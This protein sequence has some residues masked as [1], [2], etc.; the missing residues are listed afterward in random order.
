MKCMYAGWCVGVQMNMNSGADISF[1]ADTSKAADKF[2][3]LFKVRR[4]KSAFKKKTTGH[5]D[6]R[7]LQQ[8]LD[9]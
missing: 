6:A 7:L 2:I 3:P 1:I 5:D 8:Q 4:E 9:Q